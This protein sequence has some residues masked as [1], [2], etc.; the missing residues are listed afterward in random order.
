MISYVIEGFL[1]TV[2]HFLRNV[3]QY[4]RQL[5]KPSPGIAFKGSQFLMSVLKQLSDVQLNIEIGCSGQNHSSCSY[6]PV[7]ELKKL[8]G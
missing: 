1:V 6:W 5:I 3:I 8:L 4:N 2:S 7:E